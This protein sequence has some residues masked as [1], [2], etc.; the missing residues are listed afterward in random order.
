M[1]HPAVPASPAS[2]ARLG[3]RSLPNLTDSMSGGGLYVLIAETQSAR[4]PIL[5][6]S[7]ASAV[8][9]GL[10]CTVIIPANPALFVQRIES[11][12]HI[13]TSALIAANALQFF[14]LQ[15]EF[16]KKMFRFGAESFVQELAQYEIPEDSYLLFDQADELLSLH[17]MSL[18]L[19]QIYTLSQWF[20]QR[21]VTALLVFS[22]TTE[23][24]SRTLNALM[25]NLNGIARLG[26]GKD[27]L[28]LTFDYWQSPE[29]TIAA[30]NYRLTTLDSGMYEASANLAPPKQSFDDDTYEPR[31]VEE[32]TTPHF[33]YMDP[34]LGSLASQ[35][36]GSWQ[37]VDTL[38]GMMHATR[39]TRSATSILSFHRDTNLRQLAQAIHTLRLSLGRHARIVVQEKG[40]SLRYQN[41]ALLLRLGL[42]LVVNR[43]VP[44]S[45]LPLLLESLNG[46]IFNRD[47]NIDFEAALASVLPTR[48]RGYLLPVRF[49]REVA[50]ILDQAETLNIPCALVIGKPGAGGTMTDILSRV[51]L[52]RPGDLISA[53][54]ENF[55]LFLNACPQSVM[56]VTLERIFGMPVDEAFDDVRFMVQHEEIELELAVLTRAAEKDDLPDY[57]SA[58]ITPQPEAAIP[59]PTELAF[60]PQTVPALVDRPASPATAPSSKPGS[61]D[62]PPRRRPNQGITPPIAPRSLPPAP[63]ASMAKPQAPSLKDR[64]PKAQDASTDDPQFG[65]ATSLPA[66]FFGRKEAPRAKRSATPSATSDTTGESIAKSAH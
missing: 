24:H 51:G 39:N 2:V 52:S 34:D 63:P 17:D 65:Y 57:A 27:G 33:F 12:G 41:E 46:Q 26:A 44:S 31:P 21:R 36:P 5:A 64:A 60:F 50:S 15:E 19:D 40:A 35:M 16:S 38:V 28:E 23:A 42:N 30:R 53:D 55:Y 58:I 66:P 9:D 54:N 14:E 20:A 49:V 1:N 29:G 45:R 32:E 22:R 25:D 13:D 59:A 62:Q 4:F 7:L 8:N 47:V 48:L 43:E 10:V 61:I 11:Y 56:L 6:S 3:V 37:R 18:A